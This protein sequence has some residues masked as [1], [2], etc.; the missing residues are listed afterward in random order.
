M[1]TA[2]LQT[3]IDAETKQEAASLFNSLGL[4]ITTSIR[5]FL[6][7]SINQLEDCEKE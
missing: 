7:Q 5:L 1:A 2:V 6:R 4:D 3:R